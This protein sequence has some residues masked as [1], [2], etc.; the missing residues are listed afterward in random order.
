MQNIEDCSNCWPQYFY[1][2]VCDLSLCYSHLGGDNYRVR[3]LRL[4]IFFTSYV[5]NVSLVMFAIH[6]LQ[7]FHLD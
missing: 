4:L 6:T 5:L 3:G 7:P 2:E 1:E